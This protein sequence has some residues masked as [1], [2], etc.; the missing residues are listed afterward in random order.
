M[1]RVVLQP[2]AEDDLIEHFVYLGE[3]SGEPSARRFLQAAYTTFD[4]LA[5]MPLMGVGR[6]YRNPRFR[7]VRLWRVGGFEAYLIFYRPIRDGVR[8][9]RIVYGT[10]DIE[11][12]F[13]A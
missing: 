4:Q 5:A 2:A 12:L 13:D 1:A 3:H 6:R 10:R 11:R 8:I 9:L 7:D